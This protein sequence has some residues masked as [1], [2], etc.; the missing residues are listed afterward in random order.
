MIFPSL[1]LFLFISA[2]FSHSYN[3][4]SRTFPNLIETGIPT[5]I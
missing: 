1:I 5:F 3:A 2:K 4:Y